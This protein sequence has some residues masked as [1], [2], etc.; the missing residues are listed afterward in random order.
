METFL[1]LVLAL[2]A[3][4][5]LA[6]AVYQVTV[7]Q[8][9]MLA[10]I[11]RLERLTAE[12]TM[13][14]EALL[15]EIDQRM[16]RLERPGR[17]V[18]DP[19]GRRGAG[20][21]RSRAKSGTQPQADAPP[22]Q[23]SSGPCA[24]GRGGPGSASAATGASAGG[25]SRPAEAEARP[26]VPSRGREH[27]GAI[28]SGGG[29]PAGGGLPSGCRLRTDCK[30]RATVGAGRGP[31]RGTFPRSRHAPRPRPIATATCARRSGAWPTRARALWRSPRLLACPGARCCCC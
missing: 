30:P 16:A 1:Y 23:A 6:Y 21:A 15:D 3:V 8:Q 10:E 20:R 26:A 25:R 31:Y 9:R 19:G 2:A 7:R 27:S 14:A 17:P 11:T 13:S 4:G 12:V 29:L 18:G 22:D 24:A 5:A 28:R